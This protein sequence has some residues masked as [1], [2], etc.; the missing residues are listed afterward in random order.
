MGVRE[1]YLTLVMKN[2]VTKKMIA[3][4]GF[5]NLIFPGPSITGFFLGSASWSLLHDK[6]K[7][8]D[9]SETL[10][11]QLIDRSQIKPLHMEIPY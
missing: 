4:D 10:F 8:L 7:R 3:K 2:C 1:P 9:E 5:I 6:V 11:V